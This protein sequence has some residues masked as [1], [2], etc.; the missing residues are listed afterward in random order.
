MQSGHLFRL[1]YSHKNTILSTKN[2]TVIANEE[3]DAKAIFSSNTRQLVNLVTAC[4]FLVIFG[5]RGRWVRERY[6][7]FLWLIRGSD[8][9]LYK[10]TDQ[11]C[12]LS[13]FTTV[14]F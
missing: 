3:K 6:T 9:V 5:Q 4:V 8:T 14:L 10:I 2:E 1:Q 12:T 11:M 13:L 7:T